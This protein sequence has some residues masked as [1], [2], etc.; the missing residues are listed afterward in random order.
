MHFSHTAARAGVGEH[1]VSLLK[2]SRDYGFTQYLIAP[3]PLLVAATPELRRF[4][5]KSLAMDMSGPFDW[6]EICRLTAFLRRERVDILHCHMAIATLCGAPAARLARVPIV[7]ETAHGREIWREGKAIKGGYWFDRQAG[8]LVD[9]FIAVSNAVARHLIDT[10][11]IPASKVMV[12]HNGRD[13]AEF[14]PATA[15][16]RAAARIRLGL[17]DE[18]VVLILGRL[19]VEKGHAVFV[20]AFQ[21]VVARWPGIVALFAGDGPE[22][23]NLQERCRRY[24]L[25]NVIRF[26]GYR[27]DA[28]RVLAAADIVVIPSQIE[29]L[30]L[31]AV[32]ALA[33]AKAVVA[34]DVGGTPEI[35]V[36]GKTGLLVRS[37][38]REALGTALVRLLSDSCLRARLGRQGRR[39]VEENYSEQGQ[40]AKTT[41][42]YG[43]LAAIRRLRVTPITYGSQ[44]MFSKLRCSESCRT[45]TDEREE[46]ELA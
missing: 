32:E 41:S 34:T 23:I 20:E 33:M 13:L 11:K 37:G 29:G 5:I 10:K 46:S 1:V 43:E 40:I 14:R 27:N 7:I 44:D 24:G 21:S 2:A 12:I 36:D 30:P 31:V 17:R 4:G 25:G 18:P 3:A 38:D 19:S 22:E 45:I 26:L 42:L 16:E 39:F 9:R 28:S 8:R 6:R 35:I 15:P